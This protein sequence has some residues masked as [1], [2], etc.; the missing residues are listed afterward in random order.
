MHQEAETTH[1]I[2]YEKCTTEPE[3]DPPVPD[4]IFHELM[5]DVEMDDLGSTDSIIWGNRQ[6]VDFLNDTARLETRFDALEKRVAGLE[7]DGKRLEEDGKQMATEIRTLKLASK[8]YRQARHRFLE[9]VCRDI[10]PN[11]QPIPGRI[12]TGNK[13]AHEADC[14][15]DSTLYTYKERADGAFLALYGVTPERVNLLC[16]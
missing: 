5:R 11:I 7:E 2:L 9:T 12:Q 8:G 6:G 15:V 4:V 10:I 13:A 14:V 1:F 3:E 16:E